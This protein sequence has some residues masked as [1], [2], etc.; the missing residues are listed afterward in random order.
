MGS[1]QGASDPNPQLMDAMA[2]CGHLVDDS[3]VYW[4]L[5]MHRQ[6]LFPDELF[7]DLFPRDGAARRFRPTWLPR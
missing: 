7:V 4:L 3:S 6:R 2:V 1:V 5:A